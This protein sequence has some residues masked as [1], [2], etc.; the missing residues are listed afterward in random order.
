MHTIVTTHHYTA[1]T[2]IFVALL[3]YAVLDSKWHV[4]IETHT[5]S[6]LTAYL[7]DKLSQFN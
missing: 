5:D 3:M 2:A 1:V 6:I 4:C 7:I